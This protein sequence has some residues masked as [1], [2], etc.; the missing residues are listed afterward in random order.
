[1]DETEITDKLQREFIDKPVGHVYDWPIP[2]RIP[3][4][5]LNMIMRIVKLDRDCFAFAAQGN[6]YHDDFAICTMDELVEYI[7]VT[8]DVRLWL[9]DDYRRKMQ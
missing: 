2:S 1:M 3:S 9:D 8:Y 6:F 7:E 5:T 4:D